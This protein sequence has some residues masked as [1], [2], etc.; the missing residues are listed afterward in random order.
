MSSSKWRLRFEE[1]HRANLRRTFRRS[2]FLLNRVLAY[3]GT[4]GSTPLLKRFPQPVAD[5]K[6]DLRWRE[7]LYVDQPEEWDDPYRFFRW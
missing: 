4:A 2:W 5:A 6:T 1:N 3:L 7:G